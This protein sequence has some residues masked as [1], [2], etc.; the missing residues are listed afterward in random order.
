MVRKKESEGEGKDEG[1]IKGRER[2]GGGEVRKR[3]VKEK[4]GMRGRMKG[5]GGTTCGARIGHETLV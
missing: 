4:V 5:G 2:K 1:R 3:E